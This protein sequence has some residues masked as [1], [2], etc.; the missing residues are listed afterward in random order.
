METL[1]SRIT[2]IR[3]LFIAEKLEEAYEVLKSVEEEIAGNTESLE[4][5]NT[6]EE[7][8]ILREDIFDIHNCTKLLED[9]A[10]W[11]LITDSKGIR[12]YAK[13]GGTNFMARAEMTCEIPIFSFLSLFSEADLLHSWLKMFKNCEELGSP[14]QFRRL[15]RYEVDLP[16]PISGRE[17]MLRGLGVPLASS[18]SALIVMKTV[19][20]STFLGMPVPAP[21]RDL[22]PIEVH[23]ACINIKYI[24]P[25][26]TELTLILRSNPNMSLIPQWLINWATKKIIWYFMDTARTQ[27]L[28]FP[29]S[30]YE[31]RVHSKP[32]YY[33]EI[34]DRLM[35]Y[36]GNA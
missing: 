12:T 23:L 25:N 22:V 14:T 35:K 15:I 1:D 17:A 18:K 32:E 11:N 7:V 6:I 31:R 33:Q 36:T 26:H 13:G 3:N 27:A 19:K 16:W 4:H 10:E 28:H 8:R 29:G 20:S 24:D 9:Q 2:D 5:L 21:N 34:K 30:E